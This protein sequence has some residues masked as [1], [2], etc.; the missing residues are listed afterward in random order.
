VLKER[1]LG[2]PEFVTDYVYVGPLPSE[3]KNKTVKAS[4][5]P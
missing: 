1:I 3:V 5:W 4:F 2:S